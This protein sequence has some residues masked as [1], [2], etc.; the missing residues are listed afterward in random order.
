MPLELDD[1]EKGKVIVGQ[2][3]IKTKDGAVLDDQRAEAFYNDYMDKIYQESEALF[4]A[5][6]G[7]RIQGA[8]GN[9]AEPSSGATPG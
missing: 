3:R 5:K 1:V 7:D 6:R 4:G 9:I 8:R 2:Q